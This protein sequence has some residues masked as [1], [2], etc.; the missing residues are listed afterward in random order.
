[1]K[2]K[3]KKKNYRIITNHFHHLY[4]IT[5]KPHSANQQTNPSAFHIILR[6]Q[7]KRLVEQ[8]ERV[9]VDG[10]ADGDGERQPQR[11]RPRR[12]R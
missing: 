7:D 1:M 8:L 9:L 6:F 2:K 4:K 3:K 5:K 12:R 10:R 11:R